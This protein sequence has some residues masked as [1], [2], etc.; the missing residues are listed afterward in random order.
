MTFMVTRNQKPITDVQK[1][2]E[3]KCKQNTKVIKSQRKIKK[4]T[5][6]E[7]AEL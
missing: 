1:I 3:K 7:R 5:E 2:K 6:R 4:E